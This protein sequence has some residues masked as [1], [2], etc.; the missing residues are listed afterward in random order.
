MLEIDTSAPLRSHTQLRS[1]VDAVHSAGEHDELDWIEWKSSLDLSDHG[2]RGVVAFHILGM[3]NRDPTLAARVAGGCGYILVGVEP[4]NCPGIATVDPADLEPQVQ[5]FLG[6]SA[7]TWQPLWIEHSG[8]S[9]LVVVVDPPRQG[10][11]IWTLASDFNNYR[12]GAVLVRRQGA[13]H[14][15]SPEEIRRLTARARPRDSTPRLAVELKGAGP[16]EITPVD[17]DHGAVV[18]WLDAER[19]RLLQPLETQN[20]ES[21]AAASAPDCTAEDGA[22]HGITRP[23]L[24]SAIRDAARMAN[25]IAS[26]SQQ[27]AGKM[28][29]PED[30]SPEEY[31]DQVT[32][33]L[34]GAEEVLPSLAINQHI[35]DGACTVGLV[36]SNSTEWPFREV[37]FELFIPGERVMAVDDVDGAALPRAPR[38]WGD[39]WV[40]RFQELHGLGDQL[41]FAS[42]V[43]PQFYAGEVSPSLRIDNSGSARLTFPPVDLAPGANVP[44]DEFHLLLPAYLMGTTHLATWTARSVLVPG[45][46]DGTLE[47]RVADVPA[48][49]SDLL[50]RADED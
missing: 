38:L 7:P 18:R 21:D 11:P 32:A 36:A 48:S 43:M 33:Y 17:L 30:R 3:A 37:E 13:T 14:Q 5:R 28:R 24:G 23:E 20:L 2:A 35:R 6:D 16:L 10:D 1:L 40:N 49:M 26:A 39:R 29:K 46:D 42:R 9:V 25:T 15:A 34:A 31:R 41:A 45:V 8:M 22:R 19:K 4:G 47:F 50:E 44:L 27:L 12:P